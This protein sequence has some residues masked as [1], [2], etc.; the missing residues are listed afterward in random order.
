MLI[1]GGKTIPKD[2]ILAPMAGITDSTFRR[3]AKECGCG[4]VYSEMVSAKGLTYDN[5]RSRELLS[6]TPEERPIALQIFGSEPEVMV[7]AARIVASYEPDFIDI[8]MGCPTPKIVKNGDGA[9]L[10][11]QPQL[12]Y[13]IMSEV[14]AGVDIPVLV[15]IRKGWDED[16]VN[17]LE[18][19]RLAQRAGIAAVAIHGRTREQFY[20]GRADWQIIRE[21]KEALTIPVIGNGDVGSWEE[22]LA[23]QEATGCDGVMIGRGA[24]G[25]PWIFQGKTPSAEERLAMLRRHLKMLVA[26]KGEERGVKE[27]RKHVGWYVKG[28][29]RGT[30][31]RQRVNQIG[32]FAELDGAIREYMVEIGIS[33]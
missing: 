7:Q 11:R 5:E 1:I 6:F 22:G 8:N 2:F 14:A 25:N 20:G 23:M 21:V 15:K 19:A 17:A 12:A 29:T 28:L 27:A 10:L 16:S 24:L 31:L 32:T 3:L 4:L 9:A 18:I 30:I 13:R 33:F 26:A